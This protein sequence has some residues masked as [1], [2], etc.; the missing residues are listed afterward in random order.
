MEERWNDF[1]QIIDRHFFALAL[2]APEVLSRV[3][4]HVPRGWLETHPRYLMAAAI[5]ASAHRPFPVLDVGAERAFEEWVMRQDQPA[6]RDLLGIQQAILRRQLAAGRFAQASQTAD[7][8]E[9]IIRDA[10]ETDELDDILPSVLLRVGVV[11]LQSGEVWRAIGAFAEAWRWCAVTHSHPFAPFAAAYCALGHALI[12]DYAQATHWRSVSHRHEG[13]ASGPMASRMAAPGALTDLLLG[14]GAFDR[15]AAQTAAHDLGG[16]ISDGELWWVTV[17]ARARIALYWGDRDAAIHILE[18][19]LVAFPSLTSPASLAG[20]TLRADLSDLYQ[21]EGKFDLAQHAVNDFDGDR[22]PRPVVS[23][24]VRLLMLRGEYDRALTV[25]ERASDAAVERAGVP[26]RWLVL[27]ANLEH[28]T[29]AP[30]IALTART[31]ATRLEHTRTYDAVAEALPRVRDLIAEHT[32]LGPATE[33]SV[34][35]DQ[36]PIRLTAREQLL[37]ELL[38]EHAT[39]KEL[40]EAMF[41]SPNTVKSHLQSLYRKLGAKNRAQAIRRARRP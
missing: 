23:T 30:E 2:S 15:E 13:V 5:H 17:H 24:V 35:A 3:W 18:H 32:A 7:T 1:G 6:T 19:E 12:G 33:R 29:E 4:S 21:A 34:F 25:L 22:P 31:A 28:L 10:P 26:V 14:I 11:R 8:V 27:E 37:L 40:A 16:N 36:V 38:N 41:I 39:V 20:M 9:R